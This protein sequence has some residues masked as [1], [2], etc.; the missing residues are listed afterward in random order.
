MEALSFFSQYPI[1][2]IQDFD[3]DR[4]SDEFL[5]KCLRFAGDGP[6]FPQE[7]VVFPRALPRG[8]LYL[9]LQPRNWVPLYPFVIASNCPH[10]RYRETYLYRPVERQKGYRPNEELRAGTYGRENG[11]L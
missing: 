7:R 10:C 1:R 5:L 2:L 9:C 11:R 6:G 3:I 4:R 8:D